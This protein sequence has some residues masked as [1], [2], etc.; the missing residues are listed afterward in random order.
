MQQATNYMAQRLEHTFRTL[1]A[2]IKKLDR[3]GA[4]MTPSEQTLATE[5]KRARLA[6]LD[7]MST[8]R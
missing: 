4:H 3:R 7:K 5:L 6:V 1:D 8:L 2:R